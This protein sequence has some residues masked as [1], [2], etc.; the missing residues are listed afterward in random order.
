MAFAA[1][2]IRAFICDLQGQNFISR[3]ATGPAPQAERL[4]E[5]LARELLDAGGDE[6]LAALRA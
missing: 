2:S 4:A 5:Q 1:L 6:I 3:V